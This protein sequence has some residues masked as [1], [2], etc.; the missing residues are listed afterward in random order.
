M[1]LNWSGLLLSSHPT[2]ILILL[3]NAACCFLGFFSFGT[4]YWFLGCSLIVVYNEDWD[5]ME[6]ERC[7]IHC[8]VQVHRFY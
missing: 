1:L 3:F 7:R 5:K 2:I 8:I 4:F 6:L